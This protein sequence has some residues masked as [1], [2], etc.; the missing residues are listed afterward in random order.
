[1]HAP[2][3]DTVVTAAQ[4]TKRHAQRHRDTPDSHTR[5]LAD[6]A[7][8]IEGAGHADCSLVVDTV[9]T[10]TRWTLTVTRDGKFAGRAV[11]IS[12]DCT[13]WWVVDGRTCTRVS[14]FAFGRRFLTRR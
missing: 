12:G 3:I 4:R 5:V 8:R 11:T 9:A 7:D 6:L 14:M 10:G 1:M 2:T 13:T